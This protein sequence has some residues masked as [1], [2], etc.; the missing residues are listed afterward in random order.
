MSKKF[1]NKTIETLSVNAVR[2]SIALTG[3]LEPFV[4]DND[5]GPSWDGYILIYHSSAKKKCNIKGKLYL[6]VKGSEIDCE[7]KNEISYPVDIYDLNN[8]LHNG[9][10]IYFV[11]H[12]NSN[13][14]ERQIYYSALPPTKI[15]RILRNAKDQK[16]K[17]IT[18]SKFP[19]DELQKQLIINGC[20]EHCKMQASFADAELPTI[21]E[22]EEKG[23]LESLSIP[24]PFVK[25]SDP[26]D[27]L[28]RRESYI[29]ANI[30]GN[31]VPVPLDITLHNPVA[32]VEKNIPV[33]VGNRVFYHKIR[34][35]KDS[36]ATWI[37]IGDSFTITIESKDFV[38][39]MKYKGSKSLRNCAVDLDFILS[40]LDA[41]GFMY[42]DIF[43]PMKH[44][45][46]D[47]SHFDIENEKLRLKQIKQLVQVIDD[48][49]CKK[50]LDLSSLTK[51]DLKNIDNLLHAFVDHDIVT[52]VEKELSPIFFITVSGLNFL[53]CLNQMP[54]NPDTYQMFDFYDV[55]F[56]VICTMQSGEKIPISQYSILSQ[57]AL[58][59]SDN[60]KCQRMLLSFQNMEN[61][62]M[63]IDRAN[64]FLLTIVNAYDHDNTRTEL[65]HTA[66]QFADW[67]MGATEDE[68]PYSIRILNKFQILKRQKQ[69]SDAQ[70][71]E[72]YSVLESATREDIKTGAYL[73][74][75]QQQ[76]AEI[77]FERM[78]KE[79]Q[80]AFM[81]YP[82]YHF[83]KESKGEENG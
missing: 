25:G 42:G 51:D 27:V 67:L 60:L 50:D 19:D 72:V 12:I 2:E 74:L 57:E 54:D 13:N 18:M 3:C 49:G 7:F 62:A 41:E 53:V 32:T 47:F 55:N 28:V 29:Y 30:K 1:D 23:V 46:A 5:K 37:K 80:E 9:G 44:S 76:A 6:Q 10:A 16:T 20:Y 39:K 22:L 31:V 70:I 24:I 11:V 4:S 68:L 35:I 77:H 36:N 8:Y 79:Q 66:E 82:I 56:P 58:L 14:M 78:D 21:E 83:W 26:L 52:D 45:E 33:S 15:R 64:S 71:K 81:T 75:D 17:N 65:I 43:V 38:P 48:L 63:A 61:R 69:L 34:L 40:C 59:T 73:L